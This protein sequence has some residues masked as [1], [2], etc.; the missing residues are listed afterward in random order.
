[1]GS[2]RIW[3]RVSNSCWESIL[4]HLATLTVHLGI[5]RNRE[6]ARAGGTGPWHKKAR[7]AGAIMYDK[8]VFKTL[9]IV[10]GDDAS[11]WELS[12]WADSKVSEPSKK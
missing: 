8:V 1:M 6:D 11:S 5:W 4:L 7:A 3:Q 9:A 10:I 2:I 12:E